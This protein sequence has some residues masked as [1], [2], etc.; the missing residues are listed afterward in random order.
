[1]VTNTQVCYVG[2]SDGGQ[3]YQH[4]GQEKWIVD[5]C[6]YRGIEIAIRL[7]NGSGAPLVNNSSCVRRQQQ[8]R[9]VEEDVNWLR[10]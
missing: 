8:P 1:M 4:D 2:P 3:N 7:A 10:F 9:G 6:R 5:D